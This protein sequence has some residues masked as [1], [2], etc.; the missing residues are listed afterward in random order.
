MRASG[1]VASAAAGSWVNTTTSHLPPAG[2]L[3]T[4]SDGGSCASSASAGKRLS[5][6]ATSYS[7]AG[8]SVGWAGSSV[9]ASGLYWGGGW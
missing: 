8:N 2:A 9:T 3:G 1:R 4:V 5:N 6:T 7:P